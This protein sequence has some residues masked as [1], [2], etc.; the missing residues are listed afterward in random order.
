MRIGYIGNGAFAAGVD[1]AAGAGWITPLSVY[2][3][4]SLITGCKVRDSWLHEAVAQKC[5]GVCPDKTALRRAGKPP[6]TIGNLH[7]RVISL[8][9]PPYMR[10]TKPKTEL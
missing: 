8:P 3:E 9:H 2:K 1:R 7:R 6:G 4:G 5:E 10:V